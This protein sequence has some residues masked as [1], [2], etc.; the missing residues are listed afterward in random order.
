MLF[1]RHLSVLERKVAVT[2]NNMLSEKAAKAI[3]TVL[4]LILMAPFYI[5]LL[6]RLWEYVWNV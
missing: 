2:L 1:R 3:K 6:I 4:M 5:D